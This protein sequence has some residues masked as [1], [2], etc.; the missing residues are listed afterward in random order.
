M[1][2]M[3]HMMDA[4]VAYSDLWHTVHVHHTHH[5]QRHIGHHQQHCK[6]ASAKHLLSL[7]Q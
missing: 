7:G 3:L 4:I 1:R 2:G 6:Y 5:Q